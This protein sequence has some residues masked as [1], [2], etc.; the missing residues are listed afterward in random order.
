MWFIIV[1]WWGDFAAQMKELNIKHATKEHCEKVV[2][3]IE[4]SRPTGRIKAVCIEQ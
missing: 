2:K 4:N 3:Q 1:F